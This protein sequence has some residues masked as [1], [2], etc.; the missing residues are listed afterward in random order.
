MRIQRIGLVLAALLVAAW[1]LSRS[2]TSPAAREC[3]K[4]YDNA[5]TASDTAR[6]DTTF[7]P[8]ARNQ[9]KPHTCGFMRT[10]ARWR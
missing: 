2:F 8:S 6:I 3:T 9:S 1:L 5:R 10:S 4:L 7:A